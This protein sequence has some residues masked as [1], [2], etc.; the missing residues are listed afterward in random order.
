MSGARVTLALAFLVTFT[1]LGAATPAGAAPAPVPT[2]CPPFI[3]PP[4]NVV[5][6]PGPGSAVVT[7]TPPAVGCNGPAR[8]YAVYA[9]PPVSP[10]PVRVV[11]AP[12]YTFT[13][14][15]GGTYYTFTVTA[16]EGN[17]WSAWSAWSAW[18]LVP[19]QAP[20]P[21]PCI[22]NQQ[23]ASQTF[24][25]GGDTGVLVELGVGSVHWTSSSSDETVLALVDQH[26]GPPPPGP[27][28]LQGPYSAEYV[29][30]KPGTATVI[31]V[32]T[33]VCQPGVPCPQFVLQLRWTVVVGP[34]PGPSSSPSAC[35]S[36]GNY[37]CPLDLETSTETFS[38]PLGFDLLV[39]APSASPPGTGNPVFAWSS[40]SSDGSVV[41]KLSDTTSPYYQ[42]LFLPV[43][44][45]D[46]VVTLTGR[47]VTPVVGPPCIT[48]ICPVMVTM[49]WYI[50]A[51]P[52]A[53]SPTPASCE[54]PNCRLS[55]MNAGGTIQIALAFGDFVYID[56]P[57]A[58]LLRWSSSSSDPTHLTLANETHTPNGDYAG[59]GH[60]SAAFRVSGGGTITAVLSNVAC[61]GPAPCPAILQLS[62]T[63]TTA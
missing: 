30:G 35:A 60:Y 61:V 33:P 28:G 8:Y 31:A 48:P 3:A 36:L 55:G 23:N 25:V 54:S 2:V 14:L 57:E 46:A 24:D 5:A 44:P 26:T 13:G 1:I 59:A 29:A 27:V 11:S 51:T 22:L 45:G 4:T 19:A 40:T 18:V 37:P 63:V 50:H 58:G 53:S 12:P 7:W 9:Y 15:S 10:N 43:R 16:L 20:C 38:V 62:W 39:T 52:V 56:L 6:T 49:K 17:V 34:V 21:S 41:M 47:E 32:G 42:A